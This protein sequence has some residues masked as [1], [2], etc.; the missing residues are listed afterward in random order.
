VARY[1]PQHSTS[2]VFIIEVLPHFAT[3]VSQS[4]SGGSSFAPLGFVAGLKTISRRL[5]AKLLISSTQSDKARY[6]RI[7]RCS[8]AGG[9][10]ALAVTACLVI[11]ASPSPAAAAYWYGGW[12]RGS[13]KHKS[14]HKAH[15]PKAAD[16]AGKELFGNVQKGP[17]QIFISINQQKLHL[18]SDG[19][20]VA[21]TSIA[22]GVRAQTRCSGLRPIELLLDLA[23]DVP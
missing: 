16:A 18:Y 23:N 22:T 6:R 19:V 15:E 9:I 20:H 11:A 21:D 3:A 1:K 13:H 17:Q 10:G 14:A 5:G 12:Y 4:R 8:G 7:G 2:R